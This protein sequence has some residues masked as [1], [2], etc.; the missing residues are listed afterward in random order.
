MVTLMIIAN[1]NQNDNDDGDVINGGSLTLDK[2]PLYTDIFSLI[3][4]I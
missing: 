1:D 2:Q 4:R 3:A